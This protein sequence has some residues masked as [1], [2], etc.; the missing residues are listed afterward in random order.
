M[1]NLTEIRITADM[2][3][4]N[5]FLNPIK[6]FE[7]INFMEDKIM[8]DKEIRI[9][10]DNGTVIT[11]ERVETVRVDRNYINTKQAEIDAKKTE[12]QDIIYQAQNDLEELAE[13]EQQ[14]AD[15][16]AIIN[17]ADSL[18]ETSEIK[19]INTEE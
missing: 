15:A 2:Q 6:D 7:I 10:E 3:T 18:K 9:L 14:L 8:T 13:F 11:A 19:N 4:T 17:A 16:K 5:R 12:L 1:I